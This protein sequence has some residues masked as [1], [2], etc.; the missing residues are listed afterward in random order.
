M[1]SAFKIDKQ[2]QNILH[3]KIIAYCVR[4]RQRNPPQAQKSGQAREGGTRL[5][6]ENRLRWVASNG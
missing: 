1:Q 5:G 2:S 3:H 4:R 6:E